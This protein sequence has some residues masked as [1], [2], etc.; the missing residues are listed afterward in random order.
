[1][2]KDPSS[3]LL[4]LCAWG[5]GKDGDLPLWPR[6]NGAESGGRNR[7]K[8]TALRPQCLGLS[9]SA[10]SGMAT[11]T[12]LGK[13]NPCSLLLIQLGP[14]KNVRSSRRHHPASPLK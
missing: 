6:R 14:Q 8:P 2:L 12:A 7:A 4:G 3:R 13:W 5:V 1:M 9:A 11:E 10:P